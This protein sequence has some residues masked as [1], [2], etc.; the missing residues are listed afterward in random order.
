MAASNDAVLPA[1][2]GEPAPH[3]IG[4]N[5]TSRGGDALADEVPPDALSANL[6]LALQAADAWRERRERTR[7]QV[8][9]GDFLAHAA[10]AVPLYRDILSSVAPPFTLAHFP[11]VSRADV[12]SDGH[13]LRADDG[14]AEAWPELHAYTN[15]TL[16]AALRVSFDLPS[17]YDFNYGPYEAAA[18]RIP[19]LLD[20][21]VPGRPGVFLVTDM[22]HSV[23]AS[24]LLPPLGMAMLR[25]LPIARSAR[26]DADVV[27]YLRGVPIPLLYGKPSSLLELAERDAAHGPGGIRAGAVLVSGE[28][29]Y[30]DDRA[31]LEA[32]TGARVYNAYITTEGGLVAM[33]C[34]Y[35]AG[36]HVMEERVA[37][38]VLL[39][40]GSIA[41]EGTGEVLLTNFSNRAHVF[42]RYR[43]GD[44]VTLETSAC[45]CGHRGLNIAR[46]WG[47]ELDGFDTGAGRVESASLSE[48]FDPRDVKQYQVVQT[49]RGRF[50]V[51]W[52][53]TAADAGEIGRGTEKIERA[54]SER[55]RGL[56][57][58]LIPVRR[59][60]RPGGKLRRFLRDA[61]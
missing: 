39:P 10:R 37:L 43:L 54:L 2:E 29:L 41:P 45:A 33:E 44:R 58:D 16:S 55:L 56:P 11:V 5:H 13:P 57:F 46:L 50:N 51:R 35:R 3:E 60:M 47:R 40:D 26:E 21:V 31:K 8:F 1:G 61:S 24:V 23:R 6:A 20:A 59:I 34:E 9:P 22:P 18:R 27:E 25:R 7:E 15:G 12:R 30:E 36:L 52:I 38:E 4:R 53:P 17:W 42:V 28:S 32:W 19:G 48:A 49:A 14:A